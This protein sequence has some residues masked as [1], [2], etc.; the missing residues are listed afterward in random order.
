MKQGE[1]TQKIKQLSYNPFEKIYFQG[2]ISE[3]PSGFHPEGDPSLADYMLCSQI[4]YYT[5][6]KAQCE[7][8]MRNSM[9]C[10][11]KYDRVSGGTTYLYDLVERV[12][13]QK[14]S[15]YT[16]KVNKNDNKTSKPKND[17]EME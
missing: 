6:S 13:S 7:R 11:D 9:I 3:Y 8:L 1:R 14:K 4:L 2:D 16:G 10:R 5:T 17:M 12:D 15:R